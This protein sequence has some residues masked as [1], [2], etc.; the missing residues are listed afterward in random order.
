[1]FY[2]ILADIV[3]LIH[4]LWIV[5]LMFGAFLGRR[6]RA[7]KIFHIGGV[8][9]AL[10]IQILGWY[11]PLTHLEAWLRRMHNP[12]LSY[13]GSF[14]IHYVEKIIY[15]NLSTRTILIMTM[16]LAVLSVWVYLHKSKS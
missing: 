10:V 12:A 14:I 6:Y 3:V 11:C 2:R 4:F 9:F 15:I 16:V 13:S 1:M 7:V 5:F 8:I